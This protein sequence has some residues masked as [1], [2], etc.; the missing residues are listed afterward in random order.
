MFD[1]FD[2]EAF[3]PLTERSAVVA[4]VDRPTLVL[5]STQ[6]QSVV[7]GDRADAAGVEIVRRRSGGGAVLLQP[8]DHIWVNVWVPRSDPLWSPE[9]T[10]S[11][12]WV[13]EWWR[14]A[15][16]L[17]G[18][19]VHSGR[20]VPGPVGALV[21][22]AGR[23]PGE[24]FR[25]GRKIM[26]L[27][28]WRSREGSLFMACTYRHW[29]PAVLVD[30]LKL[31]EAERAEV[32]EAAVGLGDLEPPAAPRLAELLLSSLPEYPLPPT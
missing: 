3:R 22:F 25:S 15:L 7:E 26:G 21:C 6:A 19:E 27:S 10:E 1:V 2:V 12:L 30:L 32:S 23:G 4:E 16:D 17:E 9:V 29:D 28:Q 31:S 14:A 11:A 5:G 18:C 13:G 20:A 8:G 24:V